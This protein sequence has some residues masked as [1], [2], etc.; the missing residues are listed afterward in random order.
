MCECVPVRSGMSH[1]GFGWALV[2]WTLRFTISFFRVPLK[3][4]AAALCV[5][6]AGTADRW[7]DPVVS[8]DFR[9]LG[10]GVLGPAVGM[11]YRGTP[12]RRANPGGHGQGL[13]DQPGTA[14]DRPCR[15]R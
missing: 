2:G 1:P 13:A 15:S 9:V 7:E 12:D 14:C 3:D 11:K 4:S 8:H 10:R 6:D 5:A